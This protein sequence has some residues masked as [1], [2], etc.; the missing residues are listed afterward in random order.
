MP[1]AP[2]CL[3][4]L[5]LPAPL[6]S[7]SSFLGAEQQQGEDEAEPADSALTEVFTSAAA[8]LGEQLVADG[9][10]VR[11]QPPPMPLRP[12]RA[13]GSAAAATGPAPPAPPPSPPAPPARWQLRCAVVNNLVF[14]IDVMAG[15]TYAFQVLACSTALACGRVAA[16]VAAWPLRLLQSRC[17]GRA[18]SVLLNGGPRVAVLPSPC[19]VCGLRCYGVPE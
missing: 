14:H 9:F 4:T 3:Q 18:A 10:S 7:T 11:Q 1:H 2:R 16:T 5:S 15:W 12:Y 6:L 13:A 8:A 17:I 19:A